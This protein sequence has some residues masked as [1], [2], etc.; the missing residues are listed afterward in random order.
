MLGRHGILEVLHSDNGPEFSIVEFNSL[1]S[2]NNFSKLLHDHNFFRELFVEHAV[3]T[4]K[5][6]FKKAFEES[7]D[8]YLAILEL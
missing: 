3:Q 5:K 8:P 1:P 4:A 7:K 2:S 6:L